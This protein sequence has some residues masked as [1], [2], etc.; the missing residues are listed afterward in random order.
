MANLIFKSIK[1]RD[2][3]RALVVG[4]IWGIAGCGD[5]GAVQ[6]VTAPPSKSGTRARMDKYKDSAQGAAKKKNKGGR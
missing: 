5:S 3:L 2:L 6:K 1:R 4:G